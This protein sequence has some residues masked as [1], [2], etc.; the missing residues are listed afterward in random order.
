MEGPHISSIERPPVALCH[1]HADVKKHLPD[2]LIISPPKTGST[3]LAS[4]LR[5]HPA[6]FVPGMKEVKYFSMYHRWLDLN[7]YVGHFRDA[8]KRQRGEASPS[9]ALVPCQMIRWI[10]SLMPHVKLVFLM[11]DPITRAWSHARHCYQH[12][13]ASFLAHQ[14]D[15]ATVPEK[16]WRAT[17]RHPWLLASGDYLGQLQRWLTV[18]PKE[19]VYV[20]LYE[21]LATEPQALL[22]RILAFLGV[23]TEQI[24]WSAFRIRERILPSIEKGLPPVFKGELHRLWHE[25][26]CQLRTFLQEEF[27]LSISEAWDNTLGA[28]GGVADVGP[29]LPDE[30]NW[31]GAVF[32][33]AFDDEYLADLIETEVHSSDPQLLLEGYHDHNLVLHRGRFLAIAQSLGELKVERLHAAVARGCD[34]P[35]IFLG[36]SLAH[37]KERVAE[38]VVRQLEQKERSAQQKVRQLQSQ[39]E[40]LQARQRGLETRQSLSETHISELHNSLVFRIQRKLDRW[41]HGGRKLL[42]GILGRN[43]TQQ[44]ARSPARARLDPVLPQKPP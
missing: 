20:D 19:Q 31:S 27:G 6:V 30:V 24:D 22:L 29:A 37:V 42:R 13:E 2:F 43:A 44:D 12:G 26:T 15:V 14:G 21:R 5:C 3:W 40:E 35:G 11:R 25:R 18:F 8:G 41:L 1:V 9:Y 34:G 33:R 38:H 36:D 23:R 4:N 16:M 32:A 39:V 28:E 17:L 10:H 7:W